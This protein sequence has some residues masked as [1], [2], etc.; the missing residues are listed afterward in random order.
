MNGN[1][2]QMFTSPAGKT[3]SV[4]PE[5]VYGKIGAGGM[6]IPG[7]E[8]VEDVKKIGQSAQLESPHPAREL[9]QGYKIRPWMYL[10]PY[11][12]TVIFDRD[13]SGIIRHFWITFRE[14]YLRQIIIRMY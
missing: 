2:D 5:N 7:E 1:L 6:D 14:K 12:E 13:G 3:F 10:E 11:K 9:G 4:S 8:A